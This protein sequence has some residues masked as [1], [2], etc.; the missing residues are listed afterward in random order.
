MTDDLGRRRLT[1]G[2]IRGELDSA[3]L[4]LLDYWEDLSKSEGAI[5]RKSS[6]DPLRV[7]AA[8][9]G[10]QIVEKRRED[11]ELLYRLIGTREVRERGYDPTWKLVRDGYFGSSVERVLENYRI[12]LDGAEPLCAI[13]KVKKQNHVTIRDI[14]LF[15]PMRDNEGD[16]RFVMVY[17]YQRPVNS[18]HS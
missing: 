10:M 18:G 11:G 6:F 3:G 12:V 4:G 2:A 15:L 17:S 9:P 14:A 8:L 13:G 1:G 5:P 16:V 7:P